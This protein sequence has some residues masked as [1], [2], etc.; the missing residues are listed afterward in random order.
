MWRQWIIV[1]VRLAMVIGRGST[2]ELEAWVSAHV[3]SSCELG[4]SSSLDLRLVLRP[5]EVLREASQIDEALEGR[6]AL[7]HIRLPAAPRTPSRHSMLSFAT[8]ASYL[9]QS[10]RKKIT[11][12]SALASRARW[13]NDYGM[14]YFIWIGTLN[15][16][17]PKESMAWCNEKGK[18][19]GHVIKV[20]ALLAMLE[21]RVAERRRFD[22]VM[23]ADMDT[24][25]VRRDVALDAYL[26]LA[27][28]ANVIASSNPRNAIIMNSGVFFLRNTRWSRHFLEGWWHRRCGYKDQLSLWST[29][30]SLWAD[31]GFPQ[32]SARPELFHNYTVARDYALRALVDIRN[33]TWPALRDDR[34]P[35]EGRC[36]RI[37]SAHQCII[38]PLRLREVL[39]LPV[40]PFADAAG[41]LLPALQGTG[42]YGLLCHGAC[43]NL[44]HLRESPVGCYRVI[45]DIRVR[46]ARAPPSTQCAECPDASCARCG[47]CDVAYGHQRPNV[48]T[49]RFADIDSCVAAWPHTKI[50]GVG[51]LKTGL[52]SLREIFRRASLFPVCSVKKLA[53]ID[54]CKSVTTTRLGWE[55]DFVRQ[56]K[57]IYPRAKF[58]LTT[59]DSAKWNASISDWFA[60]PQI[61]RNAVSHTVPH[62]PGTIELVEAYHRYND[63]VRE[64]FSSEPDRFLEVDIESPQ[65]STAAI[66]DFVDPAISRTVPQCAWPFPHKGANCRLHGHG[67]GNVTYTSCSGIVERGP[68]IAQSMG[69]G[70]YGTGIVKGSL[71]AEGMRIEAKANGG[72]VPAMKKSGVTA[73]LQSIGD[74]G[75]IKPAA[76]KSLNKALVRSGIKRT[77]K[78]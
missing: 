65:K 9:A 54:G 6:P 32:F 52:S 24:M 13:A 76:A 30:F 27:P 41:R 69:Y 3:R 64:L 1:A 40:A 56:A 35:C 26:S 12:L 39:L 45:R 29:L 4:L 20:L 43:G 62:A 49:A 67:L 53:N 34:W 60:H 70:T 46:D 17:P 37:L 5:G 66:C 61:R 8:S 31:H 47:Y 15:S 42:S 75:R 10:Q 58:I 33:A 23:Y 78:K 7:C 28:E 59:R 14:P 11:L 51:W 38:E 72:G 77:T 16:R 74:T 25:P 57:Q 18:E 44:S 2:T 73:S 55:I 48:A 19:S 36:G 71:A 63:D 50:I 22:V 68:S 21:L